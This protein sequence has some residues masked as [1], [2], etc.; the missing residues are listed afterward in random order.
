MDNTSLTLTCTILALCL[1]NGTLPKQFPFHLL[2]LHTTTPQHNTTQAVE[3]GYS[4]NNLDTKTGSIPSG[5][6]GSGVVVM[7]G[8]F[9]CAYT[10]LFIVK[11]FTHK[12]GRQ[13]IGLDEDDW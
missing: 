8:F 2:I 6:L 7:S 12:V 10:L 11:L 4:N 1:S 5:P 9:M 13:N 3:Y